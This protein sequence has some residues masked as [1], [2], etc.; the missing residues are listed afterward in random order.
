MKRAKIL[1]LLTILFI[2]S[3]CTATYRITIDKT[4]NIEEKVSFRE[5][6]FVLSTYTNSISDYINEEFQNVIDDGRYN[7]YSMN[8]EISDGYGIGIGIKKY[9]DFN[10]F[11]NNSIIITEMF[12]NISITNNDNTTTI[13]MEPKS[14]FQY[15]EESEMYSSLLDA[16]DFEIYVPYSVVDGNYDSV[17]DNVY[18]WHIDKNDELRIIDISYNKVVN[19]FNKNDIYIYIIVSIVI[20][21]FI[22]G[23]YTLIKY[24][25]TNK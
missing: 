19:E 5:S 17:S 23:L 24:K 11:K 13:H 10:N 8:T 20:L 1:V 6:T 15:F 18:K 4:G 21:I 9:S 7:E 25:I 3:G 16:V 12:Y 14:E 22:F 2:L